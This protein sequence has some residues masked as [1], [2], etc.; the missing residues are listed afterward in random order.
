MK[1]IIG[2]IVAF[3]LC[4]VAAVSLA[5]SIRYVSLIGIIQVSTFTLTEVTTEEQVVA[6]GKNGGRGALVYEIDEQG[7][8]ED[9]G[10]SFC[11][12]PVK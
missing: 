10:T 4:V 2:S 6:C 12:I 1:T 8:T 11:I 9:D 7:Y 3:I 5:V